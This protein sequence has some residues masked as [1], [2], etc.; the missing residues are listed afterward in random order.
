MAAVVSL[1]VA[2]AVVPQQGYT[3]NILT[4][5]V[6]QVSLPLRNVHMCIYTHKCI[7]PIVCLSSCPSSNPAILLPT[8]FPLHP[9]EACFVGPQ[10]SNSICG[11]QVSVWPGE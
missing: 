11:G 10:L 8:S 9:A 4:P 6:T 5:S 2:T 3:A 7:V 1:G